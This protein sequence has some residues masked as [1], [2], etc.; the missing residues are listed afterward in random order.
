[1]ACYNAITEPDPGDCLF[2]KQ[3]EWEEVAVRF[4]T[5]GWETWAGPTTADWQPFK[6]SPT[7]RTHIDQWGEGL[8][9]PANTTANHCEPGEDPGIAVVHPTWDYGTISQGKK[10]KVTQERKK[11]MVVLHVRKE[12]ALYIAINRIVEILWPQTA[13]DKLSAEFF[14][15]GLCVFQSWIYSANSGEVLGRYGRSAVLGLRDQR[16]S[17]RHYSRGS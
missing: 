10:G 8:T 7:R 12:G 17:F 11:L 5:P 9:R 1:M 3:W 2:K 16:W 13:P 6:G 4:H 15:I 14:W